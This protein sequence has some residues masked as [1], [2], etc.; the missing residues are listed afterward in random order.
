MPHFEELIKWFS[1]VNFRLKI[2]Q[3]KLCFEEPKQIGPKRF[4]LPFDFDPIKGNFTSPCRIEIKM[5]LI[6]RC[7]ITRVTQAPPL[8]P[9]EELGD[10]KTVL[11]ASCAICISP[12]LLHA[13]RLLLGSSAIIPRAFPRYCSAAP[14]A[15]FFFLAPVS[16]FSHN[17]G[18]TDVGVGWS[19][20]KNFFFIWEKRM[21]KLAVEK[22]FWQIFFT[23]FQG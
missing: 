13:A 2:T 17:A 1:L 19:R 22:F 18:W 5:L 23:F 15:L 11:Y 21:K 8:K 9:I 10:I 6:P 7:N 20:L 12:R 14:S 3:A 16:E 4:C